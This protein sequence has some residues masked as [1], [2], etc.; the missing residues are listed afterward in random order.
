MCAAEGCPSTMVISGRPYEMGR[1]SRL[2][3]PLSARRGG[4]GEDPLD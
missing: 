2:C 4:G 3:H 1:Y